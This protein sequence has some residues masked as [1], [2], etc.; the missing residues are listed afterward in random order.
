MLL[1][2]FVS[3]MFLNH[4][5]NTTFFLLSGVD[6]A[7]LLST[8]PAGDIGVISKGVGGVCLT[9]DTSAPSN[10]VSKPVKSESESPPTKGTLIFGFGLAKSS[11]RIIFCYGSHYHQKFLY[12]NK[13]YFAEQV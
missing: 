13:G 11:P 9:G 5:S 4:Q 10:N 6:A 8:E 7:G 1:S 3:K 2:V 12:H